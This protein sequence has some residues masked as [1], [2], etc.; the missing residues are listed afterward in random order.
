MN[1]KEINRYINRDD[2]YKCWICGKELIEINENSIR[3]KLKCPDKNCD[4]HEVV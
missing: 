1:K 2:D 4:S 3:L